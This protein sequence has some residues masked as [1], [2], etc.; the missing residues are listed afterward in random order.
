VTHNFP[1]SG[2]AK[3]RRDIAETTVFQRGDHAFN[4]RTI[5]QHK[6]SRSDVDGARGEAQADFGEALV[7]IAGLEQ[8]AHT[9]P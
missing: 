7:V 6:A 5:E 1:R 9:W 2:G 8:K 3:G 4:R